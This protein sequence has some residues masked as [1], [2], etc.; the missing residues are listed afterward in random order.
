MAFLL[1]YENVHLIGAPAPSWTHLPG[2][3]AKHPSGCH[4]SLP[5]QPP[6]HQ[7]LVPIG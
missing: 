6:T 1:R 4:L 7:R 3:P 5:L 2:P